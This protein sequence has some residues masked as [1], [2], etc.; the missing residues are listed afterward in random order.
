MATIYNNIH[1]ADPNLR[2]DWRHNRVIRMLS[3]NPPGRCN[4]YDDKWIQ[5]YKTFT[6]LYRKSDESRTKLL[7]EM[8]GLYYAYQLFD[9]SAKNKDTALIIESRLLA[10]MSYQQIA[11]LAKT[12]P[13]TIEWYERL[14]FNVT[15]FL[16]HRDW[17]LT[18]VLL[19][20]VSRYHDTM[21]E[22]ESDGDIF[23][24]INKKMAVKPIVKSHLDM[25][26]KHFSYFGGPYVCDMMISGFSEV[27]HVTSE[28]KV[29]DFINEQFVKTLTRRSLQAVTKFDINQYNVLEVFALHGKIIEVLK[30]DKSKSDKLTSIE[31]QFQCFLTDLPWATGIKAKEMY[32]GKAISEHDNAA[33]EINAEE[34][35]VVGSGEKIVIDAPPK[36]LFARTGSANES[37]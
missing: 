1:L 28:D 35:L 32:E 7:Y 6:L 21:Y 19:P 23:D 31:K 36:D 37:K 2:P 5:Q 10:G 30:E 9:S 24:K 14:Y 22:N 27:K 20:A 4:R 17:I 15:E 18:Q 13:E 8:P 12:I 16:S 11:D 29:P 3:T 26:L 33:Y 25:T 34:A